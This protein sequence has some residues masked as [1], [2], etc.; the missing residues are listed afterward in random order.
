MCGESFYHILEIVSIGCTIMKRIKILFFINLLILIIGFLPSSLNVNSLT[1][2]ISL[3]DDLILDDL[4]SWWWEPLELL[5]PE[6]DTANYISNLAIDKDNN[7][8]IVT[9]SSDDV[10]IAGTDI[11]IFYK[12]YDY[13]T[14]TW[15]DLELVS[16]ESTAHSQ[17]PYI[18]VDDENTA[19]VVWYDTT[20]ILGSGADADIFYK[21]RTSSGWGAV[22]IVS[23]ESTDSSYLPSMVVDSNGVIHV[24]WEDSTDY[25]GCGNLDSDIFY[26]YRSLSGVWSITQV[27]SDSSTAQS[28]EVVIALDEQGSILFVWED[29]TDYAGSGS[30][31]DI[32]FRR[33]N[34][35][36][37]TWSQIS[38]VS[39]ESTAASYSP[40]ISN[41]AGG[42]YHVVWHDISNYNG[43]GTDQDIFYK[44]CSTSSNTWSMT[45]I[46]SIESPE[47]SFDVDLV[48]DE[49]NHV[50][51]VWRESMSIGGVGDSDNTF[52]KYL[53]LNTKTWSPYTVLTYDHDSYAS[54]PK[55][56]IDTLGHL[57]VIWLDSTDH[58]LGSGIDTDLFYKKFVGVPTTPVLFDILPN[59]RNIGAISLSWTQVQDATHYEIYKNTSFIS[60][61]SGLTALDTS[62][63]T[64]YVDTISLTGNYYYAIV[65][66]NEYGKSLVSNVQFVEVTGI[67]ASLDVGE[68]III[69]GT[70]LGSQLIFS[71]ITYSLISSKIRTS[72]K[73]KK[74]K[75]K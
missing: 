67:F 40:V 35:G 8:H 37:V 32:F 3:N 38:V 12:K 14:K 50:F 31:Q 65:A 25:L 23:T 55:I 64:S 10:L 53:D 36:F 9:Y 18:A 27:V 74:G 1:N 4:S 16:T 30:D 5:T 34:N 24:S 71:L 43:V 28:T 60:S 39:S 46:I 47:S 58:L 49:G 7:V 52:F 61:I 15:N 73:T 75:K 59:P 29:D 13:S 45:E 63:T 62:N 26:K 48:V 70:V 6:F 21:Q 68:L 42:L 69:T 41:E 22:E 57:H 44:S 2:S 11:D 17:R 66:V 20:N 19:H 72:T 51:V 56:D 33:L 54:R